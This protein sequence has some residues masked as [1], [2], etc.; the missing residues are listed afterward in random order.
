MYNKR[1]AVRLAPNKKAPTVAKIMQSIKDNKRARARGVANS[2]SAI[3]IEE[4]NRR[5]AAKNFVPKKTANSIKKKMY[6][7]ITNSRGADRYSCAQTITRF[8]VIELKDR[9][10]T[11]W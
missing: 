8:A 7:G 4:A 1:R 3:I 11:H 5:V 9:D 6:E 10:S 2:C